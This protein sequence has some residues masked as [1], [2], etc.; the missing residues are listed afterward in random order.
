MYEKYIENI[1]SL[2]KHKNHSNIIISGNVDINKLDIINNALKKKY[3]ITKNVFIASNNV[4]Y[5]K[6]NIYYL[7]DINKINYN[8]KLYFLNIIKNIVENDNYYLDNN[9]YVIFNNYNNISINTQNIFKVLFEKHVY[10]KFIIIT[11]KCNNII[12][13]IQSRF[14][15]IRTPLINNINKWNEIDTLNINFDN[16]YNN[17]NL[18]LE[19]F[20][21]IKYINCDNYSDIIHNLCEYIFLLINKDNNNEIIKELKELSYIIIS[22][23]IPFKNILT[24]LIYYISNNDNINNQKKYKLVKLISDIEYNISKSYLK[25]IH[26]EKLFLHILYIIKIN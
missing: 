22:S 9:K 15:N 21:L 14:I 6:N 4:N 16:F 19:Y 10:I 13:P 24:E 8:N 3:N 2:L 12:N 18:N 23:C 7:F 1:Y 25:L 17:K 20:K 11:D 5:I 26:I